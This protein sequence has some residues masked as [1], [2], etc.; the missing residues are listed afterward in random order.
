MI[1]SLNPLLDR[2]V[3][4]P[5]NKKFKFTSNVLRLRFEKN[6]QIL[7][8]NIFDNRFQLKARILVYLKVFIMVL[9]TI[10]LL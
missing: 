1:L 6:L 8:Y 2:F 4:K 3:K 9:F 5:N 10:F 7:S